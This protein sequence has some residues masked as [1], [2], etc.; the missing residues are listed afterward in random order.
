MLAQMNRLIALKSLG[1]ISRE[2]GNFGWVKMKNFKLN[3]NIPKT[4]IIDLISKY[5]SKV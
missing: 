5:F 4:N 1:H 2:I 3:F